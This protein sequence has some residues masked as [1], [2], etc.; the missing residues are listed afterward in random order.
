[1]VTIKG[2]IEAS[3]VKQEGKLR[4]QDPLPD[5]VTLSRLMAVIM[6]QLSSAVSSM[7]T[8]TDMGVGTQ[9][10][11]TSPACTVVVGLAVQICRIDSSKRRRKMFLLPKWK[12]NE[13]AC[14]YWRF[15]AS[16]RIRGSSEILFLERM[17]L[18]LA[19]PIKPALT[20]VIF[21]H[22]QAYQINS[23]RNHEE[24]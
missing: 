18:D 6:P 24:A 2:A 10:E 3:R 5:V 15:D 4:G 20:C 23:Q 9:R 17:V 12:W 11:M 13:R 21:S 1:M 8:D 14:I 7:A 16:P 22:L 19:L